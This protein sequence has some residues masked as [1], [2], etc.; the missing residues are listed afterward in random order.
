MAL[1]FFFF[2]SEEGMREKVSTNRGRVERMKKKKG[3]RLRQIKTKCR[4]RRRP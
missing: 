3:E 1:F 4:R 2:S